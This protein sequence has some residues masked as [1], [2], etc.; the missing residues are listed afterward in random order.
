MVTLLP[1]GV[2]DKQGHQTGAEW[3]QGLQ[4]LVV[5]STKE[6]PDLNNQFVS[7]EWGKVAMLSNQNECEGAPRPV[8]KRRSHEL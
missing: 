4:V 1:P 5:T 6:L 8:G 2:V 7:Q 3:L